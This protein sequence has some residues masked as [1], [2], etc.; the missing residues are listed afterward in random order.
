MFLLGGSVEVTE[1]A[2]KV[3][4]DRYPRLS[5]VGAHH[6][7]FPHRGKENDKVVEMI[8]SS[9]PN[10]LFVG[11]G[12][13]MQERWIRDNMSRLKVNAILP[14]GSML[15]YAA[16]AKSVAPGWMSGSGLEWLYR[17]FQEPGRLWFR[18]LIGNPIFFLRVFRE[19]A[20]GGERF[21]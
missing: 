11:F 15:E 18:Y 16:G 14:A 19:L 4:R 17:L 1:R 2:V 12:M 10:I 13:P 7:F 20:R 6:G 8:R 3:I 21:Q 9:A 5:I